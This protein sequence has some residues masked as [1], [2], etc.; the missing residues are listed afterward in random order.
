MPAPSPYSNSAISQARRRIQVSSDD[1]NIFELPRIIAVEIFREK[2]LAPLQ[3]RPIAINPDNIAEIRVRDF[4]DALE[5][6]LLGLDDALPRML[7]RPDNARQHRRSH[8]QRGGV[9]VGRYAARVCDR[10][11][12]PK[13]ID[14]SLGT[15]QQHPELVDSLGDFL[16]HQ[17]LAILQLVIFSGEFVQAQHRGVAWVIGVVAGRTAADMIAVLDGQIIRDRDRLVMGDQ[18]PVIRTLERRPASDAGRRSPPQQI[19]CGAGSEIVAASIRGEKPFI[20]QVLTN[21]PGS[22]GISDTCVS[23]SAMWMTLTPSRSARRAQSPLLVGSPPPISEPCATSISACL[24]KCETRPGLAPC[25]RTA[26]V[27]RG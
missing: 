1:P 18:K 2:P 26:V 6:H 7:D 11:P 24:T 16:H 27:P 20:D 13:P 22:F 9:V 23:R 19:D 12:R 5:I 3:R 15:H 8:L 14:A 21:S 17:P 4:K 10:Q 25:V